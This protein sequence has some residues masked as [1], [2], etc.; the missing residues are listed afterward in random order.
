MSCPPRPSRKAALRAACSPVTRPLWASALGGA[1]QSWQWGARDDN[2]PILVPLAE[3]GDDGTGHRQHG[4]GHAAEQPELQRHEGR[5]WLCVLS[6]RLRLVLGENDLVLATGEVAEY[7]AH[8][9]AL[10]GRSRPGAR[11]D[12]RHLRRP[13]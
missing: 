9:A 6:G 5:N 13:G 2:G 10:V 8:V 7:D 11:R 12:P 3:P 4:H 1:E